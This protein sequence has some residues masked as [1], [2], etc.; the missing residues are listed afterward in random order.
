MD[1]KIYKLGLIVLLLGE[2]FFSV[3]L[4]IDT[5][6]G[7]ED[8]SFILVLVTGHGGM[9]LYG[10]AARLNSFA[11]RVHLFGAIAFAGSFIPFLG[12]ILHAVTSFIIIKEL[13]KQ[14]T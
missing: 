7:Y 4:M 1:E 14:T 6:I 8:I 13:R 11:E 10:K 5:M 3:P 12:F 2:L 9:Y